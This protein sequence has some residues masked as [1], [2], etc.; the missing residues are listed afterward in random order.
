[1]EAVAAERFS[2]GTLYVCYLTKEALL[3]AVL[4]NHVAR[5]SASTGALDHLPRGAA[6]AASV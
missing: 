6:K 1:M 4:E 3:H 5:L 2:K